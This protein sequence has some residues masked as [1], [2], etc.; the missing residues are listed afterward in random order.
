MSIYTRD[1]EIEKF[2]LAGR[3]AARARDY[4]LS[5]IKVGGLLIDVAVAV[6]EEIRRLGGE[7][8]F[9]AQISLNQI[10]AHYCSPPEDPIRF[11]EGD[12][13]KLDVGAHVD[14][15]V[16]DCAG[17]A[18]LGGYGMLIEASKQALASAL[19]AVAPGVP[20][21]EVGHAVHATITGM[22]FNPVSNLT[23]HAVGVY[24]VH[25]EP[26][27]PNVPERTKLTFVKGQVLAIE[28]F[29]STG[30]G[31][32][33]ER[34]MPEIFSVRGRPKMKRGMDPA[35]MEGIAGYK[36]LPF[37]RRNLVGRFPLVEVN[38]T[39][40]QLLKRGMLHAYPPLSERNDVFISQAEHTIYIGD[41]VEILT[42]PD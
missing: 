24:Q 36:G 5:L 6:E 27:I 32:V 20:I 19:D 14:G 10:A 37:A 3:I 38:S 30:K 18:D 28:P 23:G 16:G 2:R 7:P 25:G 29:A 12:V 15:F 8:A 26:Q 1:D 17:T 42:L 9:P 13:A 34:G 4:G 41:K 35:V 11:K 40:S 31:F 33:T 22:G 21:S 39:L